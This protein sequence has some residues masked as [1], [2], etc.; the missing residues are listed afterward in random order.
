MVKQLLITVFLCS[1]AHAYDEIIYCDFEF[2]LTFNE[3]DPTWKKN[4][5]NH[6]LID[7]FIQVILNKENNYELE[8][9]YNHKGSL[10]SDYDD[11]W[12][13]AARRYV[14]A[15][16]N[17]SKNRVEVLYKINSNGNFAYSGNET[18]QYV[19]F[20]QYTTSVLLGESGK[21]YEAYAY[22]WKESDIAN[23]GEKIENSNNYNLQQAQE[24]IISEYRRVHGKEPRDRG[25]KTQDISKNKT[26]KR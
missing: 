22:C 20:N 12:E 11:L 25:S 23:V 19:E 2:Q 6:N 1:S 4:E 17:P 21:K 7:P 5:K 15:K 16:Y 9:S 10:H 26:N 8:S 3:N 24:R 14:L 18:N 13:K